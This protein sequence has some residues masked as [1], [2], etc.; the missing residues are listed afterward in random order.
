MKRNFEPSL[1]L[2][3][4]HEGG[5]VDHPLDPGGATNLG[6]TRRTIAAWRGIQPSWSLPKTEVRALTRKEAGE[7]YKARYWDAVRGDDLPSGV[8]FAVFDYAVNSGVARAVKDLQ[9]VSGARVDG[10][11]GG[12][13]LQAVGR[14]HPRTIIRRLVERRIGFLR[15]LRTWGSFGRGWT[16]RINSVLRHALEMESEA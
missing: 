12:M 5:Y 11:L 4:T 9:R 15:R 10:V 1:S 13:T 6:I 16:S 8:D 7:I 3:L 2:V 14:H